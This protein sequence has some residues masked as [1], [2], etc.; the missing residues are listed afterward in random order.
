MAEVV[1]DLTVRE[2]ERA[3]T[4]VLGRSVRLQDETDIARDLSVD[5]LAL[6]NI[7]MELEDRFDISIPLDRLADIQTIGD[8]SALITELRA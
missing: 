7:V 8:L 6:M 1:T 4:T 3:V 5:S 2:I